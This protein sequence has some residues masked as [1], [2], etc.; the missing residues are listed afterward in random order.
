M[1]KVIHT[2]KA[3]QAVGPY[4]QAIEVDG[5][6]YCSGQVPL[7][8][9]GDLL[10]ATIAD[11]TRQCL[12]NLSRVLE[13]AGSSLDRAV[14]VTVYLTDMNDFAELNEAYGEFFTEDFPARVTVAVSG[15][16]K[17][18]RIEIDCIARA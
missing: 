8:P 7:T 18:A 16:P 1:K 2:D 14:R 12:S 17:G 6:I 10:Q 9:D 13:A 11:E 5:W 4:S 3:P 15:L